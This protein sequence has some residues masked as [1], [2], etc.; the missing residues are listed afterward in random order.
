MALGL[1]FFLLGLRAAGVF[2]VQLPVGFQR[3]PPGGLVLPA[4]VTGPGGNGDENARR[5]GLGKIRAALFRKLGT[6]VPHRGQL[7]TGDAAHSSVIIH[8]RGKIHP[9]P[10]VLFNALLVRDDL[11]FGHI[12]AVPEHCVKILFVL[13]CHVGHLLT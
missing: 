12:L 9:V 4:L 7:P 3:P 1:Q 11:N 13:V 5:D 10:A 6:D 2:G 8:G